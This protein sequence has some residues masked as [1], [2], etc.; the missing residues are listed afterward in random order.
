MHVNVYFQ[1]D[2]DGKGHNRTIIVTS[3]ALDINENDRR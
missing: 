2:L 3:D 1:S